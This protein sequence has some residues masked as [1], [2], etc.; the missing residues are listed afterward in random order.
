MP[1]V[2]SRNQLLPKLHLYVLFELRSSRVSVSSAV[3][4][5]EVT[6]NNYE[7]SLSALVA[8]G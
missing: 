7:K 8:N 1:P 5:M 4:F 2:A 3:G 6:P